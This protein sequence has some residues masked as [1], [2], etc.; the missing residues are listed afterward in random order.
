M[1][2]SSIL[3]TFVF[4]P[5][6]LLF[7]FIAKEKYRNL[8]LLIASL[9][10][11]AC[12]DPKALILML[13]S[14]V[15]NYL[16]GIMI[17][18]RKKMVSKKIVLIIDIVIN[19][20][21]LYF[22]KYLDYTIILFD[23]LTGK[24]IQTL[25]LALPIGI[26]FFT[27]QAMSYVIDVYRKGAAA[28]KNILNVGLYISFFPQLVAGPIV[29]YNTIA[30]QIRE[31]KVDLEK[32]GSGV[33]RFLCGFGKKILLANHLAIIA[34]NAFAYG[35]MSELP[36]A[37]AW[38]GSVAFT[39][40]IFFDFSGYSDMAIGL[41]RMFGFEFEE[42]FNY[43]YISKSITE[44]WRRWHISLSR[45]FRDYVYIPLGGSKVKTGRHIFNLFVV[46]SLTGIWHG[47][48]ISFLAWGM[49]YF[50]VLVFEKYVLK[51]EERS[52][53]TGLLW[54]IASLFII[55]F[56]WVL[57]NAGEIRVAV[58]Y[59]KAMFGLYENPL[60]SD[61]FIRMFREYGIF[62]LAAILF[63]MPVAPKF[64]EWMDKREWGQK[65]SMIAVP[66]LYLVMFLWAVSFLILGAHNPFIYFNF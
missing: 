13:C 64:G 60:Y 63:S 28:E 32:F 38:L 4:L 53:L 61:M 58:Q 39:L 9:I 56:G 1:V 55:N 11:Y 29:R 65:T 44:F 47:A 41:G 14:I 35:D 8:I 23:R 50:A 2:F 20:G 10:F 18:D 27:F 52:K 25:N 26:S 37:M 17:Q 22:F 19:L 5:F 21:I 57:F 66:V 40:Q 30:E 15:I 36:V 42:N 3:F 34:E 43:P 45:W 6:V 16:A 48:N 59:M 7:Y 49:M 33:E 24:E 51:P 12:G 54:R 62:L 31:R 46:W